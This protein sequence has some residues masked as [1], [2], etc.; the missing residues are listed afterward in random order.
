MAHDERPTPWTCAVA[1]MGKGV[2]DFVVVNLFD[3]DKNF[4]AGEEVTL[5][6]VK[7]KFL[8]V[9]GSDT[10]L[11]LKASS[12]LFHCSIIPGGVGRA[13]AEG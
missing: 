12:W 9:T 2:P 11:P 6:A 10:G 7:E 5:E 8:S 1:G 13:G 3:L 4:E